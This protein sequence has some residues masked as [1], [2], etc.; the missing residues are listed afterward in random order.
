M[1]THPERSKQKDMES[2]SSLLYHGHAATLRY[3]QLTAFSS[4]LT[5]PN[6]FRAHVYLISSIM[7]IKS[8]R[9]S[10]TPVST[11]RSP[12]TIILR[13]LMMVLL[14]MLVSLIIPLPLG[15]TLLVL[16]LRTVVVLVSAVLLRRWT[17]V[18][19]LLAVSLV[20]VL[21]VTTLVLLRRRG[22]VGVVLLLR[23]GVI[24]VVLLGRG[25]V[26][27]LGSGITLTCG[28]VVGVHVSPGVGSSRSESWL[29]RLFVSYG[30]R[31][32]P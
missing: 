19:L 10:L 1:G 18:V 32:R 8:S 11:R 29:P 22:L 14:V 31:H 26:V 13:R 3:G 6:S 20:L 4:Y 23:R 17:T 9:S 28:L 24:R 7:Y 21:I 2:V 25:L 15:R 16:A 27:L 30:R 12:T 5:I